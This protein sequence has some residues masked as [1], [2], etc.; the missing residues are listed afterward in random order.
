LS[1]HSVAFFKNNSG[2]TFF[3]IIHYPKN[4]LK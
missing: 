4:T 2:M 1:L 3:M